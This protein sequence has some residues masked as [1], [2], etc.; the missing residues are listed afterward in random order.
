MGAAAGPSRFEATARVRHRPELALTRL[1]LAELLLDGS[2][3]ERIEAER[4]LE[5]AIPEL[6]AM[7]MRSFLER[8]HSIQGRARA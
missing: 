7:T 2:P 4:H 5:L 6:D 1:R 8:A 3:R